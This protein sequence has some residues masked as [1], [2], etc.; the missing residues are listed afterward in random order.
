GE[1]VREERYKRRQ[2]EVDLY[3]Q[4]GQFPVKRGEV[5]ALSGNTGG[6]GGPHLHFELRG[7]KGEALN[8]MSL[9]YAE[10]VDNLPPVVQKVALRTMNI[11]SRIN[12]QFGRFEFHVQKSG[13]DF[14]L[15]QPILATGTIGVE[16]LAIDKNENS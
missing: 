7:E 9:N 1:Y 3:F 12:D 2:S 11:N 16:V 14:V 10:I 6:S 4:P 15:P 8:P 5:I 13:Q